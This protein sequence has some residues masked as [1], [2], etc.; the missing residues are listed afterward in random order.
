MHCEMLSSIP[1][2]Y[3]LAARSTPSQLGQLNMTA[4]DF[5][6]GPVVKNAPCNA[7]DTGSAPDQGANI[8]HGAEQLSQHTTITE[9][10]GRNRR[11][12]VPRREICMTLPAATKIQ[13]SQIKKYF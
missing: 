7:G 9:P 12:C 4:E 2:L 8:P 11:I 13:H 5:P 6:S 10:E 3:P 1:G